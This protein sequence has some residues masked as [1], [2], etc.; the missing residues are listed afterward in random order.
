M[1]NARPLDNGGLFVQLAN[2]GAAETFD[3]AD[4][5]P[6]FVDKAYSHKLDERNIDRKIV[7]IFVPGNTSNDDITEGLESADFAAESIERSNQVADQ[8]KQAC[9]YF[10]VLKTAE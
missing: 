10:V 5:V 1:A 6:S 9:N 2:E 8:P 4:L 7:L 3:K